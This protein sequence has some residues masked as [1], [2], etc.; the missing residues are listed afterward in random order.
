MAVTSL[1]YHCKYI[2]ISP[3]DNLKYLGVLLLLLSQLCQ[4]FLGRVIPGW[5][6]RCSSW[7]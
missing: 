4:A 1:M 7:Q 6:E 2:S 5:N 3:K